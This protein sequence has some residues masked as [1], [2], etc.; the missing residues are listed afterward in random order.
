MYTYLSTYVSPCNLL[1]DGLSDPI[2]GKRVQGWYRHEPIRAIVDQPVLAHPSLATD[3]AQTAAPV[4]AEALEESVEEAQ[5]HPPLPS[6]V[7]LKEGVCDNINVFVDAHDKLADDVIL[8]DVPVTFEDDKHSYSTSSS[9][10]SSGSIN[11]D[12]AAQASEKG[13]HEGDMRDDDPYEDTASVVY[14]EVYHD[15]LS[16]TELAE[17]DSPHPQ[18]TSPQI[19]TEAN[20]N[21]ASFPPPTYTDAGETLIEQSEQ[22]P[23]TIEEPYIDSFTDSKGHNSDEL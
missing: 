8:S 6:P 3:Q 14:T 20:S 13:G 11:L 19:P 21:R 22:E 5:D 2:T 4:T 12:Q 9:S 1:G 10:T 7:A 15:E 16:S 23:E 18:L 17:G